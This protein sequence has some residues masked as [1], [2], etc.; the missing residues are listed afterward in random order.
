MIYLTKASCYYV[1]LKMHSWKRSNAENGFV[2]KG[3]RILQT[4]RKIDKILD[5]TF[6]LFLLSST[7]NKLHNTEGSCKALP[8]SK[9][10][11][12]YKEATFIL[13]SLQNHLS[14]AFMLSLRK[15]TKTIEWPASVG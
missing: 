10:K 3:R 2:K 5:K 1:D 12:T 13:R 6:D 15:V 8:F 7:C 11:I 14:N 4:S 9:Y